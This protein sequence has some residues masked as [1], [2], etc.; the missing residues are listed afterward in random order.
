MLKSNSSLATNNRQRNELGHNNQYYH[1]QQQQQQQAMS[2]SSSKSSIEN[3]DDS[4]E[5]SYNKPSNAAWVPPNDRELI[6]RAKLRTGWSS[7]LSS[8]TNSTQQSSSIS[9]SG[10]TGGVAG[11]GGSRKSDRMSASKSG[12][13]VSAASTLAAAASNQVQQQ[14]MAS[15]PSN[16]ASN[17]SDAEFVEIEHVLKRANQVEQKELDRINKLFQ[18]YQSMNRPQGNGE[19]TCYICNCNFGILGATPR[20]CSDC[21]KN[22]CQTCSIDSLSL[23]KQSTIW[24]CRICAEYRDFLKKSGVWFSKRLPQVISNGQTST[25]ITPSNSNLSNSNSFKSDEVR[26]NVAPNQLKSYGGVK[27]SSKRDKKSVGRQSDG[28][29]ESCY[30]SEEEYYEDENNNGVAQ[31]D[32]IDPTNPFVVSASPS[33]SSKPPSKQ[34]QQGRRRG[35]ASRTSMDNHNRSD[36]DEYE[37]EDEEE[38]TNNLAASAAARYRSHSAA[39]PHTKPLAEAAGR[40]RSPTNASVLSA[41]ELSTKINEFEKIDSEEV[42]RLGRLGNR[43]AEEDNNMDQTIAASAIGHAAALTSKFNEMLTNFDPSAESRT[44][45]EQVA[46]SRHLSAGAASATSFSNVANST[47]ISNAPAPPLPNPLASSVV[48]HHASLAVDSLTNAN[49]LKPSSF[50][51]DSA[52]S[53]NISLAFNNYRPTRPSISNLGHLQFSVEYIPSQLQ[54]KID[55]IGATDLPSKDSNG[56]SDPYVKL[57]LLPGIAKATKLRSKTIYKNLN[58][59][60]NETFHYDGVTLQDL[61]AKT[62]RLT[63]LDEDKFG[64]DFI[65]EYRLPLKTLIINEVNH[66]NVALEEKAKTD[67][68]TDLTSRGKINFALKYSKQNNCLFVKINRCTQLLPM[69]NGKSSDPFVEISLLPSSK[70]GKSKFKTTVKK[71]TLDPDFFEEFKFTNVDLRSLLTKTIEICV[72]DKDFRKNDFIG[73]VQ[74]GQNRTGD[75]LKHFFTMIK[76]PEL[77]HE[78]WHTLHLRSMDNSMDSL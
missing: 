15:S 30:E 2:R 29:D 39:I 56:L 26:F 22:V 28:G 54:L 23:N 74:L 70:E 72:W 35:S 34:Q 77:Y 76:N 61:D 75:E 69:D 38:A 78:Q 55:L 41:N 24:L 19:T 4:A 12:G 18:R 53:N 17:I 37:D 7:R 33:K 36:M 71:K 62:L 21:L 63:V 57:H 20:I 6:I 67:D 10:A 40:Q 16:I 50:I 64:F 13:F 3:S 27:T 52:L 73:L 65:G 14:Q 25:G 51:D 58:P 46:A 8:A 66:F 49:R 48:R 31:K 32:V 42:G 1:K 45:Q 68:E 11:L 9:S 59:H 60:F 5:R 44:L 43:G 47:A